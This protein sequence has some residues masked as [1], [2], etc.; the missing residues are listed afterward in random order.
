MCYLHRDSVCQSSD[1]DGMKLSVSE[2]PHFASQDLG[3]F[4]AV[5]SV[6]HL[7]LV[8]IHKSP[9]HNTGLFPSNKQNKP[10]I[11]STE[12]VMFFTCVCLLVVLSAG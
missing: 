8:C 10:F 3:I 12:E 2:V 4:G 6:P 1:G 9:K 5:Q 11:T 7:Q